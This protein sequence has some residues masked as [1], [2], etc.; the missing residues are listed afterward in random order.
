M[1]HN[2]GRLVL[3]AVL[4]AVPSF[5]QEVRTKF[6]PKVHG[7]MFVNS[8]K[9]DVVP[10][11]NISTGGLCGGMVYAAMDYFLGP[12]N[13]TRMDYRPQ[14]GSTLEQY[15]YGRQVT[16]L[17][18]NLDR[19][20]DVSLTNPTGARNAELFNRGLLTEQRLGEVRKS[21]DSG[22]PA[23]LGL[24]P[25]NGG[26]LGH[27]VLAI[28]YDYGRYQGKLGD[29]KEDLRLFIYDP[30]LP[31]EVSVLR[32]DVNGQ[33]Y[34]LAG[35][36]GQPNSRWLTYFVDTRFAKAAPPA[37][38]DPDPGKDGLVR[39]LLVQIN[40]G[41]DDLRG[42]ND[43]AQ[44]SVKIEGLPTETYELNN[45]RHWLAFYDQTVRIPLKSPTRV[46]S[47]RSIEITT[48]FARGVNPEAWAVDR[49][50]VRARGGGVP[51][52][53]LNDVNG[54][55]VVYFTTDRKSYVLEFP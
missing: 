48:N 38:A 14:V 35:E 27:Q 54:A 8:F 30:N 9:N 49:V 20:T 7:F 22:T 10:S 55:P 3:L 16:S 25:M 45:R 21:I 43:N 31:G 29:F 12:G 46:E 15:I 39:E 13:A 24:A 1:Q 41:G 33:C 53:T 23:L 11:V 18:S 40:T 26:G 4:T 52:R 42:N 28:G 36:N 32:P 37:I 2:V 6:N 44:L 5:A 19:W 50:F 17:A 51:D 47:I 34:T